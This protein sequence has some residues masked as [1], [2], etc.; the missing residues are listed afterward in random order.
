MG[1]DRRRS[2][3]PATTSPTSFYK[4]I[5]PS[6]MHCHRLRVPEEFSKKYGN[7]LS[8]LVQFTVRSGQVCYMGVEKAD[9]M[10][11]FTD[12]W[13]DSEN[14][15]I[16]CGVCVV[17]NYEGNSKF[18]SIPLAF[19]AQ[20]EGRIPDDVILRNHHGNLWPLKVTK[21]GSP[22]NFSDGW[23]NFVE[24]SSLESGDLL[25]FEYDGTHTFDV[26]IFSSTGCLKLIG[27]S[28]L[29]A[30]EEEEE[31]EEEEEE[32]SEENGD[33]VEEEELE[34]TTLRN[35]NNGKA[36]IEAVI[37][38]KDNVDVFEYGMVSGLK[39]PHFVT[40]LREKKRT[41][42]LVPTNVIRKH[43]LELP[44][45][46][47]VLDENEKEWSLKV[48]TWKDGRKW[49]TRGWNEFCQCHDLKLEDRCLCEFVHGEG[50]RGIYLK[51]RILRKGS[52]LPKGEPNRGRTK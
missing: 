31:K 3:S 15:S 14:H 41:H 20:V 7:E 22:F 38:V 4:I 37:E 34:A 50:S 33:V 43:R 11:W 45:N 23:L 42:L 17:F 9:K 21:N 48:I 24:D 40:K 8:N 6:V 32:W 12:G 35:G 52:W 29:T 46:L 16:G 51:I 19:V 2:I 28:N 27:P 25:V 39:T 5:L 18:K 49:L 26:K 1:N 30:N 44:E 10:L 13:K 47:T 36:V